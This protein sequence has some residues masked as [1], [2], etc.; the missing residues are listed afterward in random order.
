MLRDGIDDDL[1]AAGPI[2]IK[3]PLHGAGKHGRVADVDDIDESRVEPKHVALRTPARQQPSHIGHDKHAMREY[4]VAAG[5]T[6][7]VYIDMKWRVVVRRA[8]K[9]GQGRA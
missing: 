5:G 9:Q 4:I 3:D 6:H 1:R 2:D 8:C 7:K